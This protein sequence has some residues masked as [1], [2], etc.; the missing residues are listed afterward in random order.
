MLCV[1]GSNVDG[2]ALV[3]LCWR[4]AGLQMCFCAVAVEECMAV[5][6]GRVP[7]FL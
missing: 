5:S 7:S 6:I 2:S 3:L 1:F 4:L